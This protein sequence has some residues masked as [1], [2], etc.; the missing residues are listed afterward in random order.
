M[1][2]GIPLFFAARGYGTGLIAVMA[3]VFAAS[4]IATYL[5]L[6]VTSASQLQSLHFGAFE[7]HGEALSGAIIA[8]VGLVFWVWP[9]SR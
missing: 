1:V 8:I 2:E 9:F 3:V 4:T 7:R 5:V 6:C